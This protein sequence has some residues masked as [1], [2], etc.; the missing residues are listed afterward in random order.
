[1]GIFKKFQKDDILFSTIHARPRVSARYGVDVTGSSPAWH[2]STGPSASLSLYGG[3]R[4]R[5][6]VGP[7]S[8]SGLNVYP[9][10]PMDTHSIDRVILVSGSYPST[11]SIRYVRCENEP[12]TNFLQ[13]TDTRWY[14][15]H[16]NPIQGLF[17]YYS[18]F[19]S[20]YFMGS[21]DFYAPLFLSD[22]NTLGPTD[23]LPGP[24]FAFS[25]ALDGVDL[26]SD[27][28]YTFAAIAKPISLYRE[29]TGSLDRRTIM[30]RGDEWSWEHTVDGTLKFIINGTVA[31]TSSL[32]MNV[33]EWNDIAL[34]VQDGGT[35]AFFLNGTLEDFRSMSTEI[36]SQTDVS[37]SVGAA[38]G[39][40]GSVHFGFNGFLGETQI[41]K[42]ALSE[43]ELRNNFKGTIG[44]Q[45]LDLMHYARYNDGPYG[46]AHGFAPGSGAFD[47]GV[48]HSSGQLLNWSDVHAVHWQ[49]SDHPTFIPQIEKVNLDLSSI[50]LVHVPSMF[51]GKMINPGSVVLMDGSYNTRRVVRVIND[52]GRGSLYISG[53]MTKPASGE[54]YTG[55]KRRKVGNVFYTEG[56]IVLT[57]PAL[58]DMFDMSEVFWDYSNTEQ[59]ASGVFNDLFS[60]SFEGQS[61]TYTKVFNCRAS[62]AQLNASNNNT[63]SY[64][65][66]MGTDDL[67]DDRMTIVDEN[68]TTWITAIGLYNEERKLIAVAKLA[69]PIR[70]REGDKLNIRLKYDM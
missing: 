54:D 40:S 11:G 33:G 52:D 31:L 12:F 24:M 7:G 2:G 16:F 38:P 10:D 5:S 3:V 27:K 70:K 59:I 1:M 41:W 8:Q 66:D 63:F 51:Y 45:D 56:L 39:A 53:S 25:G 68:G 4:G 17:D 23:E 35:G 42:R 14:Q 49:P 47:Y 36:F 32:K 15:E 13:V 44:S 22:R 64:T 48:N 34:V 57:D 37:V 65:D 43:A 20:N 30:S 60:V 28:F 50:R 69:Q 19:D 18:R 9:L 55:E 61:K 6:D 67:T 21:Y 62:T 26:S 58:F 46:V 29:T